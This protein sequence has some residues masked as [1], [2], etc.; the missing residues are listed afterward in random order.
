MVNHSTEGRRRSRARAP[1]ALAA[2]C[3]IVLAL[4][5]A[6]LAAQRQHPELEIEAPPRLERVARGLAGYRFNAR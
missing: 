1:V 4:V 5:G 6:D 2:A 3:W